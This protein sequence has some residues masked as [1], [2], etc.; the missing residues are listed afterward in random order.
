MN[1]TREMAENLLRAGVKIKTV[2][3]LLSIESERLELIR[4]QLIKQGFN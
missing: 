1:K 2:A 4:Q 3:K